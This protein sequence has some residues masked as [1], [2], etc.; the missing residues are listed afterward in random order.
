MTDDLAEPIRAELCDEDLCIEHGTGTIGCPVP[1]DL[2][3]VDESA[4]YSYRDGTQVADLSPADVPSESSCPTCGADPTDES[5]LEHRLS[6][7]GYTHDDVRLECANPDCENDGWTLG[8]PI[9]EFDGGS[10]LWCASCDETQYLVHRIHVVTGEEGEDKLRV[11]LK[12]PNCYH[13]P[14]PPPERELDDM[15]V[16]LI[17]Y[18]QITGATEGARPDGYV[19]DPPE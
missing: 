13:F 8:V 16:S 14:L 1:T 15:G 7:M 2:D 11:H 12:C 17:G 18:P 4:V 6:D 9:G 19:D 10:D 5:V 3:D